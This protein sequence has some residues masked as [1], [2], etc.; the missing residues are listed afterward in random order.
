MIFTVSPIIT[1]PKTLGVCGHRRVI[2]ACTREI[3]V[4]HVT[5]QY[6]KGKR[7]GEGGGTGGHRRAVCMRFWVPPHPLKQ[8]GG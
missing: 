6:P 7:P 4:Y 5:H 1:C 2:I 8:Q 3:L